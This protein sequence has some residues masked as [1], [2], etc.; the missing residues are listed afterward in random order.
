MYDDIGSEGEKGREREREKG[1]ERERNE[2]DLMLRCRTIVDGYWRAAFWR[3]S[4]W[5]ARF[6]C[7]IEMTQRI[8][9]QQQQQQKRT[10]LLQFIEIYK[11]TT[12][13]HIEMQCK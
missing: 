8:T 13:N 4:N 12:H 1:R 10:N 3:I 6:T 9:A 2:R 11:R 7:Q 5:I